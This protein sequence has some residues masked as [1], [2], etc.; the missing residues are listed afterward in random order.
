MRWS[1]AKE[2]G[3]ENEI[4][5]FGGES[6]A[7]RCGRGFERRS[8]RSWRSSL[9]WPTGAQVGAGGR[10][11]PGFDMVLVLCPEKSARSLRVNLRPSGY[12]PPACRRRAL[13]A[14][15]RV[16]VAMIRL[17]P[18][19][20]PSRSEGVLRLMAL[21]WHHRFGRVEQERDVWRKRVGSTRA[22][23]SRHCTSVS[24]SWSCSPP[25]AQTER[26]A[27]R[28]GHE[29]PHRADGVQRD[30]PA[31]RVADRACARG[32]RKSLTRTRSLP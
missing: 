32:V 18:L 11:P 24:R 22:R 30:A 28:A 26:R 3:E 15:T 6:I 19:L 14:A 20:R 1:C 21:V 31:A 13:V 17:L 10:K 25:R 12:Q 27:S 23:R 16:P 29:R 2:L 5:E 9:K 4:P 7:V 8:K